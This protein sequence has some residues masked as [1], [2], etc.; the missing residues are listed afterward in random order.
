MRAIKP[1]AR[2]ERLVTRDL[3]D[4]LLV[5]DLDRHKAYCLNRVAAQLFRHCD[6]QTAIPDMI[7]RLAKTLGRPVDEQTI[8]VGLARL[9][10]A[11][12]LVGSPDPAFQ[13]SRREMLRTLGRAT[14]VAAPLVTV[15]SVPMSAEAVSCPTHPCN[16]TEDCGNPS[17]CKCNPS[18]FCGP[19]S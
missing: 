5:Y 7:S 19:Q 1:Q 2:T 13:N 4:E 11:R 3:G 17:R 10:K 12:L 18:K 14:V 15:L 9:N 16:D 6:G 8:T